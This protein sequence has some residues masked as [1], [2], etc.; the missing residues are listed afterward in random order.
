MVAGL[1]GLS[2]RILDFS[3]SGFPQAESPASLIARSLV[4]SSVTQF[5]QQTRQRIS[6]HIRA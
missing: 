2:R 5:C 3:H 4:A 6:S 1:Q